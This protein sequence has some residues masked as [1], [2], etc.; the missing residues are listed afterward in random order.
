MYGWK[1][2]ILD[3]HAIIW[4][5][6]SESAGEVAVYETYHSGH[7]IQSGIALSIGELI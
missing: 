7:F 2:S 6:G 5:I 1:E 4:F 3:P